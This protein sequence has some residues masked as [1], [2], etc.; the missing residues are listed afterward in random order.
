MHLSVQEL[1]IIAGDSR[2][3]DALLFGIIVR[4]SCISA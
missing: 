3:T 1:S 2:L 4:M